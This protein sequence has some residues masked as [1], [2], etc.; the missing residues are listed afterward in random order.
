MGV[1]ICFYSQVYQNVMVR[2]PQLTYSM[3]P[4]FVVKLTMKLNPNLSVFRHV[5][6]GEG[7]IPMCPKLRPKLLAFSN[8]TYL[9]V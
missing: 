8:R 3:V 5:R 6:H 9:F 7:T 1:L 2:Y 4:F